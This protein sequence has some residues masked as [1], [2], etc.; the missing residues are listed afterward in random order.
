MKRALTA[1]M[2]V[3]LL[4]SFT[5]TSGVALTEYDAELAV[6]HP[7]YIDEDVTQTA[8]DDR[9]VYELQYQEAQIKPQ[10]FDTDDVV[11]FGV[12][13]QEGTLTYDDEMDLYQFDSGGYNGTFTAYWEV[14]HVR[15]VEV[16]GGN[17]T[18]EETVRERY[19]ADIRVE[20]T[21][22]YT[23]IPV[24]EREDE[25][26]AAANWYEWERAMYDVWGA[27]A[28]IEQKTQLAV[29]LSHLR[30]NP[31]SALAGGYTDT[32]VLLVIG[33]AGAN[34]VVLTL[35]GA[36]LWVRRDD[37]RMRLRMHSIRSEEHEADEKLSQLDY[38]ERIR[39]AARLDWND[40]WD[41][42]T[43]RKYRE[44]A[45]TPFRAILKLTGARTPR[46]LV[47]HRLQAMGQEG[48]VGVVDRNPDAFDL[49]DEDEDGG[50]GDTPEP[51][52][53]TVDIVPGDLVSEDD[54][55]V[56][57][58]RQSEDFDEA[59][60]EAV[61]D[62]VDYNNREI[63]EFDLL[64][65]DIDADDIEVEETV[66]DI[67]E[68]MDEMNAQRQDFDSPDEWAELLL[69]FVE[70]VRNHDY[71]DEHGSPREVQY[72]VNEWLD[73]DDYLADAVGFP[74]FKFESEALRRAIEIERDPLAEAEATVKNV[75]SGKYA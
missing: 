44:L 2:A 62:A 10:N 31:A 45:E 7:S 14:E 19:V 27:G 12:E 53:G 4:V 23:H 6:E 48:Y 46:N 74:Q 29:D 13:E 5:A 71:C 43:A 65:A 16:D 54:H 20:D 60:F 58:T 47:S 1:L 52:F 59:L 33:G 55:T 38:E 51:E 56:A 73:T 18:Q 26:E 17:E 30:A 69:D 37:I 22:D 32:W 66:A 21:E 15:E 64:G 75:E 41:D 28:D 68:L 36:H 9:P 50:E 40:L 70:F 34:L 61:L 3:V 57:L 72:I 67:E 63:R 39:K 49:D 11:T 35:A 25:M 8:S 24:A 42:A